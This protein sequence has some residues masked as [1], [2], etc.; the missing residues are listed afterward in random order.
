MIIENFG[1]AEFL[2]IILFMPIFIWLALVLLDGIGVLKENFR[3]S[4]R[5]L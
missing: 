2:G 1:I 4:N 5:R 3:Y